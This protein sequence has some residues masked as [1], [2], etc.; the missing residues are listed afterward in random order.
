MNMSR[1]IEAW[2][3]F[4]MQS[5]PSDFQVGTPLRAAA[6]ANRYWGSAN[7]G[8][9]NSFLTVSYDLDAK[10]ILEALILIGALEA[11]K[12]FNRVLLALRVPL[13]VSSQDDRWNL[14]ERHWTESM[15]SHDL[16]SEEADRDL[17]RALKIH[18][19]AYEDFYISLE[20][21]E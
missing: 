1:N 2:N 13:P 18:V 6:I 5:S 16:L 12:Q 21:D 3:K 19:E 17:S 11:A 20:S 9:I 8:G 7:N 10:E 4:A 14:L 15:D